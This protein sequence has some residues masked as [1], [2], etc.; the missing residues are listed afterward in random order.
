MSV[1]ELAHRFDVWVASK[2]LK[3][4]RRIALTLMFVSGVVIGSVLAYV[5]S[6]VAYWAF[7]SPRVLPWYWALAFGVSMASIAV[8]KS[9]DEAV[10][11]GGYK[12]EKT[13][14]SEAK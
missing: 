13:N 1:K 8:W 4:Q 14:N 2:P 9:R 7:G 5:V 6:V 10:P 3:Q 12:A 11:E